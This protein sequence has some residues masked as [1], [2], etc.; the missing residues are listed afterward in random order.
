MLVIVPWAEPLALAVDD[1]EV[2]SRLTATIVL[3]RLLVAPDA[4]PDLPHLAIVLDHVSIPLVGILP[5]AGYSG[6]LRLWSS[7]SYTML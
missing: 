6:S 5:S 7:V 3:R 1:D 4:I 2:V